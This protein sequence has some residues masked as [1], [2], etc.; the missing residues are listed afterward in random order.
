[1]RGCPP[2]WGREVFSSNH[3]ESLIYHFCR[4]SFWTQN[5]DCL[6]HSFQHL[7]LFQVFI[8]QGYPGADC[9][10][11]FITLCFESEKGEDLTVKGKM[12]LILKRY[13]NPKGW[14]RFT[15]SIKYHLLPLIWLP[16]LKTTQRKQIF[17]STYPRQ[18]GMK[19]ERMRVYV[20]IIYLQFVR[21]YCSLLGSISF[22]IFYLRSLASTSGPS[23]DSG[24]TLGCFVLASLINC[25]IS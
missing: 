7:I 25:E 2:M 18:V 8:R 14:Q 20:K 12:M 3:H 6:Q 10:M 19:A 9:F 24:V 17:S 11:Y 16:S 15:D 1:M 22:L 4:I 13:N 23:H 5:I 21:S